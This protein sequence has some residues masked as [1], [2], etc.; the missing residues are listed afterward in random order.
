[1]AANDDEV[2]LAYIMQ[3]ADVEDILD[4]AKYA[5]EIGQEEIFVSSDD[6]RRIS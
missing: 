1:M 6:F 5:K 3:E 2:K 4:L